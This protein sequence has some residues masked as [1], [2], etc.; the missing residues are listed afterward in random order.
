MRVLLLISNTDAGRFP[1]GHPFPETVPLLCKILLDAGFDVEL[2]TNLERVINPDQEHGLN[3]F[4]V[5]VFHGRYRERNAMAEEALSNFV[6][7]GKGLVVLHIASSSFPG[8]EQWKALVGRVW[9]YAEDFPEGTITQSDH[10]PYGP[11]NVTVADPQHP[12]MAGIENFEIED[13][14]YRDLAIDSRAKEN[15]LLAAIDPDRGNSEPMAF[16][17]EQG[18]G[19][20]F[21]TTL[22]HGT[23]TFTHPM[24]QKMLLQA[25]EWV[26]G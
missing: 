24:F 9:L 1:H 5:V 10:P 23:P 7:E 11:F 14:M 12:I 8:S 21:H 26:A 15:V 17:L 18:K 13:E 6:N 4:D 19:R 22:G 3:P 25:V 16:T 20:V 2:A